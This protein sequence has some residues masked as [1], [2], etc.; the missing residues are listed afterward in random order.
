M[1]GFPVARY[2]YWL[3]LYPPFTVSVFLLAPVAN[4]AL[5]V[6]LLRY[7]A[8]VAPICPTYAYEVSQVYWFVLE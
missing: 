8:I 2:V 3:T 1:F 4:G 5:I 7:R 6:L